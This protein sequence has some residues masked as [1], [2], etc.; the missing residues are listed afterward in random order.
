MSAE[1]EATDVLVRITMEGAQYFLRF[2]GEGA[3]KGLALLFAGLKGICEIVRGHKK[4]GGKVNAR[5]FIEN[6]VTSDVFTFTK[7]DF[8]KLKPELKRL[9]IPYM[10]Y[11]KNKDMKQN[12]EIEISVRKDDADK[13][14]RVCEQFGVAAVPLYK[15]RVDEITEEAYVEEMENGA[16]KSVNV[17][18]SESGDMTVKQSENPTQ[19]SKDHGGQSEQSYRDLA[20]SG[21]EF[22]ENTSLSQNLA[23]AR[24]AAAYENGDL[25]PISANKEKLLK[26]SDE[27]GIV[28]QIPGTNGKERI[29]V[30]KDDVVSLAAD[31][32]KTIRAD[33]KK[34]ARYNITD[35][36]GNLIRAE[37]GSQIKAKG[38]WNRVADA[39]AS[40]LKTPKIPS[41]SEI[42]KGGR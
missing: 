17:E 26:G 3:E 20:D 6:F 15:A 19:A 14:I 25:I 40:K 29:V 39:A 30:P 10:T 4:L 8:E 31:G 16:S 42:K 24:K 23:A 38:N 2:A 5:S 28:L 12:G 9:N 21:F 32:D 33:L 36:A 13:F 18:V 22:D 11:K 34:N 7:E 27:N 1:A 41:P 37:T 35:A